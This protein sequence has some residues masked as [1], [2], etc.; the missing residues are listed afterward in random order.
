MVPKM[1]SFLKIIQK[2]SRLAAALS[3]LILVLMTCHI[4]V[5]IVLRS[6]FARSTYVLD[7]FV[8]YGIGTMTFLSLSYSLESHSL[9]RVNLLL[10]RFGHKARLYAEL[11]CVAI[12]IF[13]SGFLL[14]FFWKGVFYRDFVRHTVSS[15]I[16]QTPLWIPE[17]MVLLGIVLFILSLVAYTCRLLLGEKPV[18]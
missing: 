15:S 7:E 14:C 4:L 13:V 8:G 17:G 11:I 18:E 3:A 5:E 16:S 1:T 12:T 2:V 10:S 9:V 6:F